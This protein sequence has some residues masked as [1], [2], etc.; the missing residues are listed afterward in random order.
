MGPH[1]LAR[2]GVGGRLLDIADRDTGVK[3]WREIKVWR[4]LC[5]EI[6]WLIPACRANRL[7]MQS[8]ADRAVPTRRSRF[9]PDLV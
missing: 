4:R 8:V 6:C 7:M 2:V 9:R 1:R 5:G 3:N